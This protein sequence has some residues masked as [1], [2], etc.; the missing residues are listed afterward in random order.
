MR[1][2]RCSNMACVE[3]GGSKNRETLPLFDKTT[4]AFAIFI[5]PMDR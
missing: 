5:Y 1:I 3:K 4:A 2:K